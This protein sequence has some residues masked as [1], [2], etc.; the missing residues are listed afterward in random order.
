MKYLFTFSF[1]LVSLFGFSQEDDTKLDNSKPLFVSTSS[2]SNLESIF[3][4]LENITNNIN[5]TTYTIKGLDEIRQGQIIISTDNIG[6]SIN[7]E[8][9]DIRPSLDIEVQRIMFTGNFRNP[10]DRNVII[11][12]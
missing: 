8:S 11:K 5:T 4:R 7:I 12:H 6:K 10:R 3:K 1:I 9:I 2:I